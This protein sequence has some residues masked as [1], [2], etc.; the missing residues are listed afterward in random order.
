MSE[1]ITSLP[2]RSALSAK[3]GEFSRRALLKGSGALIVSFSLGEVAA[4]FGISPEPAFAQLVGSPSRD[5]DS[6]IAITADGSVTAYTGK[7]EIGQGLYT[8]QTQ[9]IA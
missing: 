1:K 3:A 2:R 9:L 6:W 5:L 4:R 8:A 7:C